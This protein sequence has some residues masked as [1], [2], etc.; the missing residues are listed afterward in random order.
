[1]DTNALNATPD[2]NLIPTMLVFQEAH[3]SQQNL[4]TRLLSVEHV[5]LNTRPKIVPLVTRLDAQLVR[6]PE[7]HF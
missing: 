2:S 6:Q 1:M 7:I 4:L 5:L 3:V